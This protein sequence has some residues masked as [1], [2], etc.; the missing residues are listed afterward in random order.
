M[1]KIAIIDNTIGEDSAQRLAGLYD[2]SKNDCYFV[3][4][5]RGFSSQITDDT[6]EVLFGGG[7][8]IVLRHDTVLRD[9][10][11]NFVVSSK[12]PLLG[13]CF[14]AQLIARAFGAKIV[15]LPASVQGLDR[16]RILVNKENFENSYLQTVYKRQNWSL[17]DL[18]R[19]FIII[20]CS[21]S[22]IEMFMHTD[23][24][25]AGVQFH[26]ELF[27]GVGEGKRIFQSLRQQV[28]REYKVQ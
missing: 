5:E 22:G 13:I 7:K 9:E 19:E 27:Q 14:G 6:T 10:I 4:L 16:I 1:S 17:Q 24:P 28:L 23:R 21:G 15:Q 20:A 26:P 2:E 11:F 18:P 8:A 3:R 12:V 25:I